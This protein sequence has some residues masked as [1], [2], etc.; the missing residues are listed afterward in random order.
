MSVMGMKS[1][2]ALVMFIIKIIAITVQ[3]FEALAA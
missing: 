1:C 3:T 2:Q